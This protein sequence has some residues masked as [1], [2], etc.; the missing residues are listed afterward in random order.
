MTDGAND[1]RTVAARI[2]GVFGGED[3]L[4]QM[5]TDAKRML[6]DAEAGRW[7]VDEETGSH[8]RRAVANMQSRLGDVTPRIYLLKQAPKFG[9]DEYA[10]QAADHFL[11]AMYSD[12]RSLVRVFEAA[13]ELLE[14][15]RRAIDVAISQYDA[16]E[17]A[18]TRAISAFKDQE[19]R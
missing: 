10:R 11:T 8:L 4:N 18:A 14:T 19:P 1:S 6:A 17:E 12:D 7:A 9:N 3:K 16:S 5:N 13:Q 15:L 2:A